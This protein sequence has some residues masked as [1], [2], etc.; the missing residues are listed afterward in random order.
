MAEIWCGV[1][2]EGKGSTKCERGSREARRKRME[3]RRFKLVPEMVAADVPADHQDSC[4]RQKLEGCTEPLFSRG[5]ENAVENCGSA[6]EKKV[7]VKVENGES[8]SKGIKIS[9]SHSLNLTLS[10]SVVTGRELYPKYGVASVC[11]RRRD[12]E[13]AVAIHPSFCRKRLETVTA[14]TTTGL[15]YFG[16]YDGHGCSHVRPIYFF[17]IYIYISTK[18]ATSLFLFP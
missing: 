10:P 6:S 4:K 5:C 11:G 7:G 2:S 12:M 13:D 3:I 16:L 1:V 17:H 15:H 9:R 14:S 8:E 18:S